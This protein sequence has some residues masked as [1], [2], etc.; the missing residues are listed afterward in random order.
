MQDFTVITLQSSALHFSQTSSAKSDTLISIVP[1]WTNS[2]WSG[3]LDKNTSRFIKTKAR[4]K[5]SQNKLH[6]PKYFSQAPLFVNYKQWLPMPLW[7][8]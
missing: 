7:P 2:A 8:R 1:I 3:Q 4:I 6:L 5:S